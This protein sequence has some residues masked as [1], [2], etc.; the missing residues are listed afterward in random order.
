MYVPCRPACSFIPRNGY[1]KELS[2]TIEALLYYLQLY[3]SWKILKHIFLFKSNSSLSYDILLFA[4][5]P[6]MFSNW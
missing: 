5:P 6:V 3:L 2:L 4:E 1:F